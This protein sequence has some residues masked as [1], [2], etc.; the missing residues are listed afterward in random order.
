M[1]Q[2]WT[3]LYNGSYHQIPNRNEA[4]LREAFEDNPEELSRR[5]T[6]EWTYMSTNLR[7]N[8]TYIMIYINGLNL[9]FNMIAPFL[10]LLALNIKGIYKY[11]L[12]FS[13]ATNSYDLYALQFILRSVKLSKIFTHLSQ[14]AEILLV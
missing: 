6:W 14:P 2:N 4:E 8:K 10:V 12:R 13:M 11:H 9:V 3:H 7:N 5:G 1:G